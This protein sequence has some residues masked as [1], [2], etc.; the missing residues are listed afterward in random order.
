MSQVIF[1]EMLDMKHFYEYSQPH[2][3]IQTAAN[4]TFVS[5]TTHHTRLVLIQFA[6]GG[7]VYPKSFMIVPFKKSTAAA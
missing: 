7:C 5:L 1:E 2:A 3:R 6:R 4:G